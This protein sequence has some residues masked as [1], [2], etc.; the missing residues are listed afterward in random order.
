MKREDI[1]IHDCIEIV[2]KHTDP[3]KTYYGGTYHGIVVAIGLDLVVKNSHGDQEAY[4]EDADYTY[5][6]SQYSEIEFL[7]EIKKAI[8][9]KEKDL[10]QEQ[11]TLEDMR[12]W[13]DAVKYDLTILGRIY[14]FVRVYG[15]R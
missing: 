11:E 9:R 4:K 1:K 2:K 12:E 10:I 8:Q 15:N 5:T 14:Q 3:A 13:H 6:Y 7:N